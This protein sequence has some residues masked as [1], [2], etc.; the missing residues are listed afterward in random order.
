M[1]ATGITKIELKSKFHEL[2]F[3]VMTMMVLGKRYHGEDVGGVQEAKH[4][5][6]VM[7]DVVD[8]SA[9][10]NLGDFLPILQ[11]MDISGS[12]KTMARSM[13]KI[14]SFLHIG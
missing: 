7:R 1:H 12:E 9:T 10:T 4:F 6:E 11:W 2:S 13:A 8:L 5:P 3:N 14:D